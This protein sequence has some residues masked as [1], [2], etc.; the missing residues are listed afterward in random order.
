MF[1][2]VSGAHLNPAI[3]V[4]MIILGVVKPEMAIVY[5]IADC[6]GACLGYKLLTVS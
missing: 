2:H 4:T 5:V 1:I 3:T 6:L